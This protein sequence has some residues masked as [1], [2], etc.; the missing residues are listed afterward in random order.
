MQYQVLLDPARVAS[1]GLSVTQV[2]SA[3]A[4]NNDNSG[5]GFY[6]QGGEFYYVRGL[7]RLETLEDIGDV[8]LAVHDGVP[9]LVKDV[10]KVV[11]GIAPRL[12]EFGYEN[13]DDAVEGV[14]LLRTGEK[15]QDVL[16]GVEAKTRELNDQ[17]LP[18]DV[19]VVPFYDRSDLVDLT[20]QVVER[21]L[22][23]GMVLVIVVLIFFLYDLRAGLIVAA[24]I[25]LALLFAFIC[26]DLQNASANLL[27]I[28]AIDFGILVDGAVVMVENIFRQIVARKGT[29]LNVED[30]VLDA[31]AE[32]DRP[33]FYSVAVIVAG[34]L[35]IYVLSGPSGTLFKPMADT[36]VFALVGSLIVTLTLLPVLCAWFMRNGVRERRNAAFEFIKNAYTRGLDACLERP[37]T[38]TFASAVLLAVSLLLIP[39]IGAEFMPQLDEGAL[40]VRATMPYTIS[41][42]ES[43]KIA[44]KVRDILRSFPEVTTVAS[45]LGRPDDGTDSTGFFNVEFYVDLKPYASW[46]GDYRNK[47]GLIEAINRK[48]QAFPGITFNYTQPAEDAVDEAET[49]LKSALAVKVF[50]AN[51]ET[52]Q[53]KGKSVKQILERVRGIRDVTLVQELG[54]PSLSIKINRAA[55][56]RYGLNVADINAL[57]QTAIGG[58]A[59]TQVVQQ[60]KQFDLIVRLEREYRDNAEEIGNILVATAAGQQ[61]PLKELADIRVTNGASFIYRQNNS[62]YIGVQFSVEGRDLAGAVN[63][64]IQQVNKKVSLPQGYR[65]DWGGEYSEYTASRAQLSVILPLTLF[66]IFLLLFALYSNFKF[67]FITVLGVLLSAPVGGIVALW[68]SGTPFSASSGIGFLALF[69]VSVQ[70]AIVYISYVNELRRDG[71][72]LPESIRQGAILRLRPIMMTALVAALGLLPVALATGVGTDTQRPFALVIVSGLFTRLLISIFLMPVLY[73]LVARS[74]DRLEV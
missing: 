51:L 21:N 57:V 11:I 59:A 45:E 67:P 24:S 33:L 6:S 69:G 26:L 52:L 14:I 29:S 36:M 35:P 4:A 7:G 65:L 63:D 71:T 56:A 54:Q 48:L 50:G 73:T 16:K 46:N 47:A 22:L 64:A 61:I 23:R 25:P 18:K 53:Q 58:D 34:F 66:L 1:V 28:G 31:A 20:T 3:L 30:I 9:V 32:V 19:K 55:I 74:G 27:S 13:Q 60:E 43:A 44:P 70:T 10:G 62:R 41:F 12:G 68:I 15:T 5:G 2:E 37:W 49:G 40:W 17:I 42:D 8:V 38:T 39:R 72:P